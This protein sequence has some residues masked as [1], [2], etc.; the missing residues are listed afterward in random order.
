MREFDLVAKE[1]SW[2]IAPGVKV[3]AISYNGQVPG[4][5]IRVTEGDTVRVTLKNE[6]QQSTSIHWHGLHVPNSP[7]QVAFSP[8]G[9]YVYFSLNG[10]N[11]VGKIDVATRKFIGK[12]AVGGGPVQVF[13]SEDGKYLLATN[14]GTANKPSTTVSIIDTASFNVLKT[15]ETGKGAHGVAIDSGS[16]HAY[17]T[18]IY[19]NSVS[20]LDLATQTIVGTVPTGDSPNGISMSADAPAAAPGPKV[21]LQVGAHNNG[22]ATKDD[23]GMQNIP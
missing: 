5:T 3:P 14:Q 1:V 7:V 2:E 4:P 9:S 21:K 12:V 15:V 19:G 20:V 18:N 8:D 6:L 23:G 11:A 17:I 22:D 10:E 13:V 16:K